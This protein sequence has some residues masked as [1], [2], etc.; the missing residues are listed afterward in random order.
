MGLDMYAYAIR[1]DVLE[2]HEVDFNVEE[3]ILKHYGAIPPAP[4]AANATE[5]QC[6]DQQ[7]Q[8]LAA[9][10]HNNL[11]DENFAYW[12]KFNALHGWMHALYTSKG[13]SNPEFNCDQVVV[14]SS[15]LDA[16]EADID[17]LT[18]VAGLFFGSQEPVTE[19]RK[20]EV[21]DFIRKSRQAIQD[22]YAIVYTSWW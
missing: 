2:Q 1:A 8:I 10:K 17:S 6:R 22:G 13:G 7:H 18:P 5:E 9:A 3:L 11:L 14:N 20:Q 19:E 15:D 12:R 21:R 16:L 4:N